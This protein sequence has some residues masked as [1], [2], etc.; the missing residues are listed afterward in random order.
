MKY[1]TVK[2][3]K[4]RGFAVKYQLRKL[5]L[6]SMFLEHFFFTK[7]NKNLKKKPSFFLYFKF[8][9]IVHLYFMFKK[10]SLSIIKNRCVFT[11]RGQS[12]IRFYKISRIAFRELISFGCIVGLKK[13]SW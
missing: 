8:K 3:K 13:S 11:G 12:V 1:L 10:G 4:K 9:N 2:D 5:V 7:F 6:K